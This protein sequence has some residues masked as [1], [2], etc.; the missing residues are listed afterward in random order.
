MTTPTEREIRNELARLEQSGY[1]FSD[2]WSV[3]WGEAAPEDRPTGRAYDEDACEIT[4]DLWSAQT[5]CL[6]TLQAGDADLVALLG[7]YGSGKTIFGARW[8]IAQALRYPGSQFLA[9]GQDYQKA[10]DATFKK[11][12]E[13][14]P[15]KQTGHSSAG[16]NGPERS[17]VVI[18]YDRHQHKLT[19]VNGSTI[20]LGSADIHS[21]YAGVE[22][23]GIWMDE[24]SHYGNLHE[25][26]DMMTTRLRGV[27]G[28]HQILWTLTGAGYNDAFEILER[29]QNA[30]GDPIGLDIEVTRASVLDNPYLADGRK[31][32]FKNKFANTSK[33]DQAL[34][35][36]FAAATGLV[37]SKFAREE[38]VIPATAVRARVHDDWRAYGY[39]AG[40]NHPRVLVEIGRTPHDQLV[41][42]DEFYRRESHVEDAIEW[43]RDG[44][45]PEGVIFADH[46]PAEINRF[47]QS[48]WPVERAEKSVDVGISEVRR[49]LEA[50]GNLPTR[51]QL[52]STMGWPSAVD[53]TTPN[54]EESEGLYG[55]VVSEDCTNLIREFLSYEEEKVSKGG[56]KDHALDALRY[57]VMGVAE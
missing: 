8:L 37:Y 16:Y 7:G 14:L 21:R 22:F 50:D 49:R 34:Y 36:G 4:Y 51:Q 54:P 2:D 31:E 33:A 40:W 38:H 45:K 17:P 20:I 13:Q 53:R 26:M 42:L 6:D 52:Q 3:A 41:V 23:G 48:G 29:R 55:L 32:T 15:G 44:D 57:A 56:A 11:L 25:L 9:M 39:D 5:A 18:E 27:D 30:D 19:L 46:E 47:R 35:G 1:E 12:Y 24:P 43:L 28:P 10:E